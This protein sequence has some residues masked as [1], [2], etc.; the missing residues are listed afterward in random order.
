MQ[1]GEMSQSKPPLKSTDGSKGAAPPMATLARSLASFVGNTQTQALPKVVRREGSR[2]L[3]NWFGCVLGGCRADLTDRTVAVA[4]RLS[5]PREA[6]IL[7]RGR[8]VDP[9]NAAFVNCFSSSLHAFDDTHL[10]SIAH[11]T[12]PVA[13]ATLAMA[14]TL[15]I[16][17]NDFLGAILLGLEVQCR[18]GCVLMEPPGDCS[19]AWTMTGLVG[20]VGA[21]AAV[22]KLLG[23]D[24]QQLVY[25]L[26][27]AATQAAGF[28]EGFGTMTRD[29]PMAQAARSGLISALLAAEG[30]TTS[31]SSLDGPK[32]LA[33]VF[34]TTPNLPAATRD[35][36]RHFELMNIAYKPYPC[37]IVIHPAIDACF[38]LMQ[39]QT[40]VAD[41]IER[42]IVGVHPDAI[43]VTGLKEPFNGLSAQIS[44]YHWIAATLVRRRAGLEEAS[45]VA[46]LDPL[47]NEV[48]SRVTVQSNPAFGRDGASA[49]V[50]LTDGRNL[51]A[52]VDH[53]RGSLAQPLT[54]DDLEAKLQMQARAVVSEATAQ[55]IIDLCWNIET[56]SDVGA[57]I[58][59]LFP[60]T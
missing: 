48:R 40:F 33:Y 46:A 54:D 53:C 47:I 58:R 1:L 57:E 41:D 9:A 18:L 11:P 56:A 60:L 13:A 28:R 2:A 12:G 42:V 55:S 29:L 16:S 52:Q 6:S 7:G 5:G 31:E 22:G 4:E 25:A 37:G 50:V 8:R 19:V 30:F 24:E 38:A 35:L 49:Q 34:A 23:L 59:R 14:E 15:P 43:R 36:G 44:V 26:G 27:I 51:S 20:G 17:G 39:G 3:L 10:V 32:G 45:D 21:A